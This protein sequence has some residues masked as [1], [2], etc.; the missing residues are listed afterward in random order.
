MLL[1]IVMHVLF[2]WW[3]NK[4]ILNLESWICTFGVLDLTQISTRHSTV[5]LCLLLVWHRNRNWKE[6]LLFVEVADKHVSHAYSG[7]EAKNER[8]WR[9]WKAASATALAKWI[10][11]P[12][13]IF[14]I[15][16]LHA[17]LLI[18]MNPWQRNSPLLFKTTFP[19]KH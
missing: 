9:A 2:L 8:R 12:L 19:G 11:I 3:D 4:A 16:Y 5:V 7:Q 6:I 17:S 18:R 15:L 1:C 14:E 13:Y 10:N